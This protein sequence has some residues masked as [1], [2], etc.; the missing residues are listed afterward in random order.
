MFAQQFVRVEAAH[1]VV[2]GATQ[3]GQSFTGLLCHQ[4]LDVRL[5][6]PAIRLLSD[7]QI[8]DRAAALLAAP[9]GERAGFR[10]DVVGTPVPVWID[11]DGRRM[12]G[13][14]AL[15]AVAILEVER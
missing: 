15:S 6:W 12:F 14:Y 11:D 4:G 10:M 2:A 1:T 8:A 9:P 3:R 7:R 5:D 13:Y